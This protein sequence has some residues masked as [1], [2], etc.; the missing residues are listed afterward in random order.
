MTSLLRPVPMATKLLFLFAGSLLLESAG[1]KPLP[2]QPQPNSN[3]PAKP[4]FVDGL[5]QVV[6][7]FKDPQ[8]W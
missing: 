8:T 6:P 7:A 1:A 5:A 3:D 2:A 4:V